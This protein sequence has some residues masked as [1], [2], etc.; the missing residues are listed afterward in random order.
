M[1]RDK[2]FLFIVVTLILVLVFGIIVRGEKEKSITENRNLESFPEF[3]LASFLNTDFQSKIEN[4][5]TDQILLGEIFKFNYNLF[6]NN[7]TKLVVDG[8]LGIQNDKEADLNRSK[9]LDYDYIDFNAYSIFRDIEQPPYIKKIN[10]K[11][12]DFQ[13]ALTPFGNNLGK[14]DDTDHLVYPKRSLEQADELFGLKANN[15][16]KL[17]KDY[18]DLSFTCYYIETDVDVD[19]I[20]GEISHDL[21]ENFH[22]RLDE[23]IKKSSLYINTPEDYQKYFYKTDHHWGVEGQL[24]GYKDIIRTIK[25]K[26]ETPL[27]IETINV[28]GARYNGYKSRQS[29]NYEI[30]DD[31][32][33][34]VSELPEHE[35]LINGEKRSYGNKKNYIAGNFS[36]EVGINHYGL[37]NGGDFGLVEY[38][39]NEEEKANLLVFVESF[40]NPINPFIASHFNNTY[41]IDLRY[42][43]DTYKKPFKFGEFIEKHDIDEVLFTGYYFFYA[44][45]VFL[46]SD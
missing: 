44:N 40:S 43:E 31:L 30:Y 5:L 20:K 29:G 6:K 33:L 46:I 12:N 19:F 35:V 39:F 11:Y 36:E 14:I 25:G 8:L 24:Q 2:A 34:L 18:P 4:A 37:S 10:P 28:Q 1:K 21:S 22:E 41:F 15:Y 32:S 17:V 42:Y 9:I 26:Y 23:S 3:S 27:E 45:N 38:R 7:N 13:I 16:N